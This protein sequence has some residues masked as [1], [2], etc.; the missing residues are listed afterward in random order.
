M[1]LML[2]KVRA[3]AMWYVWL[4][5]PLSQLAWVCPDESENVWTSTW[6]GFEHFRNR[7]VCEPLN[8][9]HALRNL[10]HL[11][12]ISW[13]TDL[14]Q[15]GFSI[16]ILFHILSSYYIILSFEIHFLSSMNPCS[17]MDVISIMRIRSSSIASDPWKCYL[18]KNQTWVYY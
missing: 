7:E 3:L 18:H 14:F 15:V 11:Q 2:R 8:T 1:Q 4:A 5:W 17:K 12:W 9:C 10:S 6:I 13:R 16:H